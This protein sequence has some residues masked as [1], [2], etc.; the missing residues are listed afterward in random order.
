V[1]VGSGIRR[2]AH[3]LGAVVVAAVV[4]GLRGAELPFGQG[5]VPS[6]ELAGAESAVAVGVELAGAVPVSF[7]LVAVAL[8]AVAVASPFARTPWRLAGL[9]AAMLATTLLLA[10]AAPALPLVLAAWL[11]VAGLALATEH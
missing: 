6:L 8:A 3:V 9:G 2:A 5:P 4:A 10:P 1:R 11:T 7:G